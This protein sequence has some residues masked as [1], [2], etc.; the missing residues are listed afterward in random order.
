MITSQV[1]SMSNPQIK[2]KPASHENWP[3]RE[4]ELQTLPQS[5][6]TDEL[7][8]LYNFVS[9]FPLTEAPV[10][11]IIDDIRAKFSS[12]AIQTM[13]RYHGLAVISNFVDGL[14]Y[15][16]SLE[17]EDKVAI[18]QLYLGNQLLFDDQ[19]LEEWTVLFDICCDSFPDMAALLLKSS[20]VLHWFPSLEAGYNCPIHPILNLL[21]ECTAEESLPVLEQVA[22]LEVPTE[23]TEQDEFLTWLRLLKFPHHSSVVLP[24]LSRCSLGYLKYGEYQDFKDVSE[25]DCADF[26]NVLESEHVPQIILDILIL[27]G[28]T[29]DLFNPTSKF[30]ERWERMVFCHNDWNRQCRIMILNHRN[31]KRYTF[32]LT[33]SSCPKRIRY[34]HFV[35]WMFSRNVYRDRNI[36]RIIADWCFINN[37]VVR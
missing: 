5:E 24:M 18:K 36:A 6:Y 8:E 4:E 13:M 1:E 32:Y 2:L 10:S 14:G 17:K 12:K 22:A 9:L 30:P 37:P 29:A 25:L 31:D 15:T 23:F 27:K 35:Y 7:Y 11:E 34:Y 19:P 33:D 26:D 16:F 3:W 21:C 28:F 20:N